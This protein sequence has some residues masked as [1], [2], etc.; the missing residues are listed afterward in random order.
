M[1]DLKNIDRL[2]LKGCYNLLT[3]FFNQLLKDLTDEKY[4]KETEDYIRSDGFKEFCDIARIDYS[5]FM[6]KAGIRRKLGK[7]KRNIPT[8]V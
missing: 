8:L 7:K 6:K 1:K 4:K 3:A 2:N 5:Y